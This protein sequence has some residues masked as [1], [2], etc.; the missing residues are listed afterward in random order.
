M[1][2][3]NLASFVIGIFILLIAPN[4]FGQRTQLV[5]INNAG[6]SGGNAGAYHVPTVS[7][8]GR[9]VAFSSDASDLVANDANGRPDVFMRDMQAGVTTLISVNSAGTG[10]GSDRSYGPGISADGRFVAFWSNAPDLVAGDT[11]GLQ[12]VF[13]RDL[14]TGTTTRIRA[15]G[16]GNNANG[17]SYDTPRI[18][19][20]G[21]YVFFH[22]ETSDLVPGDV[23]N[24]K[25]IFV[26]DMQTGLTSLVTANYLNGGSGDRGADSIYRVSPD[27]RFVAFES[28]ATNLIPNDHNA[29]MYGGGTDVFVRDIVA[30]STK[31]VSLTASGAEA[32]SGSS[33]AGMTADGR[34]VCFVTSAKLVRNDLN[35]SDDVYLRDTVNNQTTL[36]SIDYANMLAGGARPVGMSRDGRYILMTAGDGRLTPDDNNG[37]MD[38][39]VRDMTTGI[40][41]LVPVQMNRAPTTD[42]QFTLASDDTR[43]IAL[44][45]RNVYTINLYVLD[46]IKGTT[47][48]VTPNVA[49]APS[50]DAVSFPWAFSRESRSLIFTSNAADLFPHH[51]SFMD[52]FSYNLTRS[53]GDYDGDGKADLAVF[54]QGIWYIWQS[55]N[56]SLRVQPLGGSG[57]VAIPSSPF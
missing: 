9:F 42:L 19:D 45:L 15:G 28:A 16:A 5:S 25:D 21:R 26:H 27:G 47:T 51:G 50:S 18:S 36:V 35:N 10:S 44:T 48:L 39:F 11:N 46:R 22:T 38:V 33:L 31:R 23:N 37:L 8:N 12:D 1:K 56:N 54:R 53:A 34:L 14:V 32:S 13:V 30:G 2:R 4:A 7:A 55:S 3:S 24:D 57:D 49:G 17:Q 40:T 29:G 41:T 6:T 52:V 43:F 20:D